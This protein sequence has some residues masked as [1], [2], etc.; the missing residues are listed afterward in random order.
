MPATASH[1]IEKLLVNDI[2]LEVDWIGTV[3]SGEM[4]K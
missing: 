1:R 3:P 2:L 4:R